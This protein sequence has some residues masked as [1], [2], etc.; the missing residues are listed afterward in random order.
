MNKKFTLSLFVLLLMVIG[1]PSAFAQVSTKTARID[2]ALW[3]D[4]KA[5]GTAQSAISGYYGL[6]S[7]TFTGT[8]TKGWKVGGAAKNV[9]QADV[10]PNGAFFRFEDSPADTA[11]PIKAFKF[12]VGDTIYVTF[13]SKYSPTAT[14]YTTS[15]QRFQF[16]ASSNNSVQYALQGLGA[17]SLKFRVLLSNGTSTTQNTA[18]TG[19]LDLSGVTGDTIKIVID[20]VP[21]FTTAVNTQ[22][23]LANIFVQPK[24]VWLQGQTEVKDTII[25]AY[26]RSLMWPLA[27]VSNGGNN[28]DNGRGPVQVRRGNTYWEYDATTAEMW[29]DGITAPTQVGGAPVMILSLFPGD[30][31]FVRWNVGFGPASAP[32]IRLRADGSLL[33]TPRRRNPSNHTMRDRK[34]VV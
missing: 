23:L 1:L 4:V 20:Q 7:T 32:V 26:G 27:S 30:P 29:T 5:T 12:H 17:S 33:P 15:Q 21:S 13:H 34:S 14:N 16:K 6:D 25:V 22:L 28:T 10:L 8:V 9:V 31:N 3:V 11:T 2:S 24:S 18:N 19:T